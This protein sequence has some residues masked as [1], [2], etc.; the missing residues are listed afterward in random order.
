MCVGMQKWS[1]RERETMD[2]KN[3]MRRSTTLTLWRNKETK[4]RVKRKE[5]EWHCNKGL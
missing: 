2:G 5:N 1:Q 4:Q 3:S